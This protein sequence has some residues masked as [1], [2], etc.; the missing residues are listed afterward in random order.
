MT[1]P[2][3]S[4]QQS[5]S[6]AIQTL[7]EGDT[8]GLIWNS[9]RPFVVSLQFPLPLRVEPPINYAS[10]LHLSQR[11][12]D[13]RLYLEMQTLDTCIDLSKH[14]YRNKMF[15]YLASACK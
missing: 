12:P 4:Q 11:D 7:L 9:F 2:K 15:Q 1:Q 6:L 13:I 5:V 8:V 14:K 10:A 3:P